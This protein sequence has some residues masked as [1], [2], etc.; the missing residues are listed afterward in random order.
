MVKKNKVNGLLPIQNECA[1][2]LKG[3]K[4]K[5]RV[6]LFADEIQKASF[7]KNRSEMYAFAQL[8]MESALPGDSAAHFYVARAFVDIFC[9]ELIREEADYVLLQN[10]YDDAVGELLGHFFKKGGSVQ[11]WDAHRLESVKNDALVAY[12]VVSTFAYGYELGKPKE[13]LKS[14][15]L[16]LSVV[17]SRLLDSCFDE[18]MALASFDLAVEQA[19]INR[20]LKRIAIASMVISVLAFVVSALVAAQSFG[21]F[22]LR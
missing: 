18:Q 3:V 11:R 22:S 10:L 7:A 1:E 6:E 2:L 4:A 21:W 17:E 19:E 16:I 13:S 9:K 12:I 14:C 5:Y 20:S 8:E 15:S